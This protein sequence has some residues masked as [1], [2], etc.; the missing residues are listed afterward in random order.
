MRC[1]AGPARFAATSI[2]ELA[3]IFGIRLDVGEGPRG[4][5][6]SRC[7]ILE[8]AGS[9]AMW[10]TGY[11]GSPPIPI[12]VPL[13]AHVQALCVGIS[14]L[15][16]LTGQMV[17]VSPG[18]VLTE[19][20]AERA[21]QRD[22]RTSANG[23]SRLVQA[24]DNWVAVTLAREADL[25]LVPAA[26]GYSG[27]DPWEAIELAARR[28]RASELAER[29]Q[30]VGIPIAELGSVGESPKSPFRVER[31]GRP[32]PSWGSR[33]QP[34]IVDFS[35]LWAGPLCAHIL[36][37]AGA[38]V[39]KVEDPDR[40]DG[41]R[42]GDPALFTRLHDGHDVEACR[43]TTPDGRRRLHE[44]VASADVVIEASRPRALRQLGFS[45]KQFLEQRNGRT[46]ISITGY[47]RSGDRAN[48]VA[49][50]DDAAVAGGLVAWASQDDPVFCADALADPIS[51]LYAAFGGLASMR[52]GGGYLIDVSM[53]DCSAF[54]MQ[55]PR[56]TGR[57][58]VAVDAAGGWSVSHDDL[59]RNVV[60]PLLSV[61]SQ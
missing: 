47:G 39:V 20:A 11:R 42:L 12:E 37:A 2:A 21:L 60:L 24:I 31:L 25:E 27:L 59:R 38:S 6:G 49:F 22:G 28:L 52:V 40:P 3:A 19:R 33:S 1:D 10:L 36:G 50:G 23:A 48:Y 18:R 55:G 45:P 32:H 26:T 51:G 43:F 61:L 41:A 15:S 46:W 4:I 5:P 8:F 57:H 16:A 54:V 17:N 44:L 13:L 14:E 34:L 56:C 9:G 30:L 53:C 35:A 29:G 58:T 7:P